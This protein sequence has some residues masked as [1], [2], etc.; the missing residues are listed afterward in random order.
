MKARIREAKKELKESNKSNSTPVS[1][2]ASP[3]SSIEIA[4]NKDHTKGTIT[5]RKPNSLIRLHA[6]RSTEC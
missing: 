6:E 3:T 2:E 4:N 5:A 1:K